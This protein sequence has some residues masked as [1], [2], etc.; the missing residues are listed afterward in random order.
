MFTT[1]LVKEWKDKAVIALFGLIMMAAFA[2]AFIA[3]DGQDDLREIVAAGFLSVFFPAIAAILGAGAFEAEFRDGAWA[4]LL[5]RPVRKETVWLAKLA[6]LLSVLAGF[7]LIFLGLMA[8][9]PGLGG[10]IAGYK[11]PGMHGLVLN[12]PP[13]VLFTSLFFFSAAFSLSILSEKLLSLVLGSIFLSSFVQALL[14]SVAFQAEGRGLLSKAGLYPWLDAYKLALVLSCLAF[15][16]ASLV[17]FRRADFSQPRKKAAALARYASL[18]LAAAWLL[19][20]LWPT[21]RPGRPEE[22]ESE[23][24]VVGDNA[25]FATTRGFY[26][27]DIS[28]DSLKKVT[29]WNSWYSRVIINDRK[30]LYS[31]WDG[32][33]LISLRVMNLDGTEKKMLLGAE[34]GAGPV[35]WDAWGGLALSPDGRRAAVIAERYEKI[36]RNRPEAVWIIPTDG[37]GK[38][39]SL[40]L[41]PAL[42]AQLETAP[43]FRIVAWE[44]GPE[45]LILLQDGGDIP[46]KLWRF[47]LAT[48]AQRQLFEA[49]RIRFRPVSAL[50]GSAFVTYRPHAAGPVVAAL[51]DLVSGKS[52]EVT[53]VE[54]VS[55]LEFHSAFSS[56]SWSATGEDLAFLIPAQKG[57]FIPARFNLKEGERQADRGFVLRDAF[58]RLGRRRFALDPR[59]AQGT[60]S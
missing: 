56:H 41:D 34:A 39:E 47:D 15:L 10:I 13:L 46:S 33:D 16:A 53:R 35:V 23:I 12:M 57:L 59:A 38:N 14:T 26:R 30:V 32:S 37:S 18:F 29:R 50:D 27:Y 42:R 49:V 43:W 58:D 36:G 22:L 20:A 48:G 7:W 54:E 1:L 24:H 44:T 31:G 60:L 51:I 3:L 52:T 55:G 40:R 2:A 6:A 9:V 11:L 19:S 28:R 8:A 4:Y 21:L 25:Y 17:T 5:S 45:S